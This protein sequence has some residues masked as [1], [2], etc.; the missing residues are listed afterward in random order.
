LIEAMAAGVPVVARATAAVPATLQGAGLCVGVRE[1]TGVFA[2]AML[3]IVSNDELRHALVARGRERAADFTPE[4]ARKQFL[5]NLMD[6][7]L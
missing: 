4:R 3:E 1:R 6:V 5:R 7:A 2:E